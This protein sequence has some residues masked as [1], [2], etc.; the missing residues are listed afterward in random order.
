MGSIRV[1]IESIGNGFIYSDNYWGE[2][3]YYKNF[4]D[5]AKAAVKMLSRYK[6]EELYL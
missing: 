5:A 2:E 4:D 1:E 3:T 6:K